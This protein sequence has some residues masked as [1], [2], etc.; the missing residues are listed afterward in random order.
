V[1]GQAQQ[2]D[3]LAIDVQVLADQ[4]GEIADAA[5]MGTRVGVAR[6]EPRRPGWRPARRRSL[7]LGLAPRRSK[8]CALKT[9]G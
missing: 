2:L 8:A 9:S 6:V 7:R 1:A 5:R 3:L 4:G